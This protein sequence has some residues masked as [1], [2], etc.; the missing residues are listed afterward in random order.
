MLRRGCVIIFLAGCLLSSLFLTADNLQAQVKRGTGVPTEALPP[1]LKDLRVKDYFVRAVQKKV[2]IIHALNGHV[3]VIHKTTKEAYFGKEGDLIYEND[4]L[5]TLANSRCRIKFVDEDIV[6]MA[7]ETEFSVDSFED[8]R[9]KRAKRSFFSMLKGKAM[10]YA[11]RLLKYNQIRFKVR[12]PTAVLGVR[13]TK[14][15]VHVYWVS[16]EKRTEAGIKVVDSGNQVGPYLAQVNPKGGAKSFTDCF[17]EDGY[18]DV[19]GKTVGPGEMFKGE[20]GQVIPTPPE[21]VKAFEQETE[22]KKEEEKTEEKETE[23]KKKEEKE[24][25]GEEEKAEEEEETDETSAVTETEEKTETEVQSDITENVTDTTQQE[26]GT[27][28]ETKE[29]SIAEGKTAGRVG[30]VATIITGMG[31][32]NAFGKAWTSSTPLKDPLYQSPDA[33][34]LTDTTQT[35]DVYEAGH[36]NNESYKMTFQ[37]ASS[38]TKDMKVVYF[39]WG[40]NSNKALTASHVFQWHQGGRY[41]DDK[42]HEYLK[43]GWWEDTQT[44]D[45][46]LVGV[47]GTDKFY[48]ASGKVWEIEGDRTHPDYISYLRQQNF[49]AT[50][51]G[52]AKGVY[53]DSSISDVTNLT[54]NF[55]CYIDFGSAQV[56]EF[57]IDVNDDAG[58]HRVHIYNGSGTLDDDGGFNISGFSG[59]INGS[60]IAASPDTNARGG[61]AG[62]KAEGVGGL[63]QAHDGD[64]KWATGEFHGKR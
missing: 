37:E 22:V 57:E 11:L 43:W 8:L 55:S 58:G 7:P 41:T 5:N 45:K 63:W 6:T 19:N 1:N 62:G 61:C 48:A 46:G 21:V 26:T 32:T 15:G 3:V 14:F 42:G 34:D 33:T 60:S 23:E 51:R 16:E 2:G 25:E 49:S 20:T 56:T 59:T 24:A 54:G 35:F 40:H 36:Q 30:S 13:G 28:T 10:F 12:T 53:A 31:N 29:S 38:N 44:S 50:Y 39:A 9:H 64:A 27:K 52:E 18:L 47:D 4:S 17:S